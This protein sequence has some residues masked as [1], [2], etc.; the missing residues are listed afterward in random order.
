MV[1]AK[2]L[3]QMFMRDELILSI[4]VYNRGRA[5]GLEHFFNTKEMRNIA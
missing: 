4:L 1:D 5:S 3:W 2:I